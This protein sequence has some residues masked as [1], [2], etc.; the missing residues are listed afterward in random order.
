MNAAILYAKL[1]PFH[2]ARLEAAG[3]IWAERGA[4]LTCL[5]I[6]SEQANYSW[7]RSKYEPNRFSYLTLFDSDYFSLN[8]RMLRQA[9]NRAL[10]KAQPRVVV[11]NGWGHQESVAA[12]GWCCRNRVPR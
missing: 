2:F 5:E 3:K 1:A 9:I 11:I 10:D 12:L 6:A 7:G 8:Y 4:Q